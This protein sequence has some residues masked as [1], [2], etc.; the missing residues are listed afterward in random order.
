MMAG[1]AEGELLPPYIV[2]R[3]DNLYPT[4]TE[5]GP[6]GTRYN[7]SKSGWFDERIFDDWFHSLALPFL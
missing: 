2:Y 7:R 4:W 1:N 6:Q 3:A 5:N